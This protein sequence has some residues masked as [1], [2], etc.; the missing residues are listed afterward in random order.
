[1]VG[2]VLVVEDDS[3]T[4]LSLV[5]SLELNGIKTLE[6]SDAASALALS[7]KEPLA[8]ALIDLHLGQGPNGLD[9]AIELRK[10]KPKIGLVFLSSFSSPRLLIPRAE[11]PTGAI[12][13][14]KRKIKDSRAIIAALNQSLSGKA[15]DQTPNEGLAALTG[16]QLETLKLLAEGLSNQEIAKRRFVTERSVEKAI[17]RIAK[18]LLP[19]G[20][21][22]QNQRVMLAKAY[23]KEAGSSGLQS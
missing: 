10:Q 1:M 14:T 7:S 20:D 11:L 2:K 16:E 15:T 18:T 21:Q 13:L 4:R 19:E 9:L 6:A 5:A 12:Y 17:S 22:S 8:A 23:L 3:F